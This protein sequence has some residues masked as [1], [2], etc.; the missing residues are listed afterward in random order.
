MAAA[1]RGD[2][3]VNLGRAIGPHHYQTAIAFEPRIGVQRGGF[4]NVSKV[5]GDDVGVEP[6][7]ATAHHDGAATQRAAG[8]DDGTVAHGGAAFAADADVAAYAKPGGQ[9]AIGG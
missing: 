1:P 9:V 4:G 7:P 5:A 6:L 3:A 2:L 8:V